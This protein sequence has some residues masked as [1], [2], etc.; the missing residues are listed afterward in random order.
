MRY[1]DLLTL[2]R[3]AGARIPIAV[4]TSLNLPIPNDVLEQF[5]SDHATKDEFQE[6][7]G[8]VLT[9]VPRS[10]STGVLAVRGY[11]PRF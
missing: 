3:D 1:S 7:Y 10:S 2:T 11:A 6:Q 4:L 8:H 5:C 9:F